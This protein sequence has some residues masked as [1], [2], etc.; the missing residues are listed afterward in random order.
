MGT[1]LGPLGS[2]FPCT[3]GGPP[4][5]CNKLPQIRGSKE[6]TF[7]ALEVGV[8]NR[9]QWAEIKVVAEPCSPSRF[10]GEEDV[11]FPAPDAAHTG[12]LVV[13]CS[14]NQCWPVMLF[15]LPYSDPDRKSVV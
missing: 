7:I 5:F 3:T 10:W 6:H 1:P 11:P 8:R 13:S 4:A 9:S 15:T 12:C 14:R 2:R